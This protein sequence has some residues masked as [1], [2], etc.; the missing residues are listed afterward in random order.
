[1]N[2]LKLLGRAKFLSERR[3]LELYPPFLLMGVKVI[4]IS[5]EWRVVRMN[6]P[7]T[8]LS[9]NMGDSMFGG[10][11]ASL[12][13]PIAALACARVFPGHAVWTRA[14]RVDFRREGRTDLELRFAFPPE[15]ERGIRE[16]LA[17]RGRSTPTFEYGY[18]L[19]DGT[20][21]TWIH[22]TV[23]IRPYGY[24]ST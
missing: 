15:L 13:D 18:Y 19:S 22:N 12:A 21:C 7:L 5:D 3:R 10:N 2:L 4:E 8:A 14:L 1:V 23:A 9:R 17:E 16:E 11:Q 20:L 24:R 6:L